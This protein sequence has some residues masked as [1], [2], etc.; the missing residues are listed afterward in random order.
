MSSLKKEINGFFLNPITTYHDKSPSCE[1]LF[2][3]YISTFDN[4]G[5]YINL[6]GSNAINLLIQKVILSRAMQF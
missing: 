1:G 4:L 3:F 5:S 2:G 6:R